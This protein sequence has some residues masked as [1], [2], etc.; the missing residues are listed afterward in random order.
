VRFCIIGCGSI[1]TR[2]LRNLLALDVPPEDIVLCDNNLARLEETA[3]E[4]KIKNIL[5][6][7][8]SLKKQYSRN[9]FDAIII[10]LPSSLHLPSY[11]EAEDYANYF[12][13]EKPISHNMENIDVLLKDKNR[14]M[15]GY[16]W[17]FEKGIQMVKKMLKENKIGQIFS[18]IIE[19]GSYLPSWHPE[20]DYSQEYSARR[21]LGGGIVLDDI[22]EIDMALY[23]FGLE[24]FVGGHCNKLSNLKI[25]TEDLAEIFIEFE[26]GI[27]CNIHMDY[28][29]HVPTRRGKIIGEE[30]I[31][32]WDVIDKEVK[33]FIIE[34]NKWEIIKYK[35][36]ENDMFLDEMRYFIDKIKNNSDIDINAE[37]G[38]RSLKI[39]YQILKTNKMV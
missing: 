32:E 20:A 36:D 12:F 2:H 35:S 11:I 19:Y 3:K 21:D 26:N 10:A 33:I 18:C 16:N 14:I 24:K 13:I 39:A 29:Q 23:L 9:F 27:Y 4:Y 7:I 15:I 1:G 37:V 6:D 22:H 31:L 28:L 38:I 25:D 34:K 30:G 8:S 5:T 17:R